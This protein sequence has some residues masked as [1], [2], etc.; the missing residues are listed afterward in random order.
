MYAE[1]LERLV[2]M[3]TKR[4]SSVFHIGLHPMYPLV[5]QA[6]RHY[7][8]RPLGED[9]PGKVDSRYDDEDRRSRLLSL[10]TDMLLGNGDDERSPASPMEGVVGQFVIMSNQTDSGSGW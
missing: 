2:M 4:V 1:A 9:P 10:L 3:M 5:E 8:D 6:A 7:I